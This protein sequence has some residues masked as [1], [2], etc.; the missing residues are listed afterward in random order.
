[1][2]VVDALIQ[3]WSIAFLPGGDTLITERP[4]RLRIVR[5][6]KL[7]PQAVEGVPKVFH[8]GQGG[9]LEV[10]PH[11]NFASNRLLY[12]Q[13]LE[14]GRR[15][16]RDSRTALIRGR[17]ENDRLTQVEELFDAVSQ[18]RNHFS[19]KIAFDKNGFLFL[20][21]GDR[22]VPPEGKLEAH[23]AQDLTNHHGKIVRLHDD[24]RV[25]ADN[26]FVNRAGRA[27]RRSG[28]TVTATCRA[29]PFIPETGDLWADE[30]GPQ[31]GDELN[32]IQPGK[33]Y[34]WPV[35]GF[36]VNYTT[37]LAI[38]SRHAP[39]GHGAAGAGLGAVDRHLR[40]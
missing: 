26:P 37:G 7:L 20:T 38:H 9:L 24:G 16:R 34:G 31:G 14:A 28:A 36:G 22:Q 18:G 17:F 35:I 40:D 29:W 5:Q 19:G 25:P 6:G 39:R 23:P 12:H 15:P 2:T 11:P 30:H 10:M 21:L 1:M 32:R 3:P 13:L 4:G 8:S 27:S 33:N